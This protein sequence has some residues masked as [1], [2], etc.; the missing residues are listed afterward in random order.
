MQNKYDDIII[1]A[2]GRDTI[3]QRAALSIADKFIVLFLPRSFDLWI[4]ENVSSLVSEIKQ[5]NPNLKSYTFLNKADPRGYD[6]EEAQ[7]I[8]KENKNFATLPVIICNRKAFGN[9]S[10]EGKAINELKILDKKA[11]IEINYLYRCMF[12]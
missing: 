10:A 7:K 6:N 9:A 1:D 11:V 3:N 2:G 5:I 12:E 8:M 4:L